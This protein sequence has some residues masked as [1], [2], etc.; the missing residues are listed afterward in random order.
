VA[1]FPTMLHRI[2][3]AALAA[4]LVYTGFRLAHPSEFIH[5]Y[6]IG[7]EQLVIFVATIVGVLAT[8]LLIGIGIGIGM[9][10]LIHVMNGV[11]IRSLFKPYLEVEQQDDNTVRIVARQSA[12]FSNWIP[13]R[14]QLEDVGL[15]QRQNIVL[16]VSDAKLV[17]HSVMEK[18]H[19]MQRDFEQEGLTLDIIGL[20]AHVPLAS[21]EHAARKRGMVQFR[22]VVV[23]ADESLEERLTTEFIERGATGYTSIPCHGAGRRNLTAGSGPNRQ[24]RIEVIVPPKTGDEILTFLRRSVMPDY[25][26][27]AW[28]DRVDV[29]RAEQFL[30]AEGTSSVS[31]SGLRNNGRPTQTPA[32]ARAH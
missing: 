18:L 30:P 10:F 3:L 21:H 7:R 28:F 14:R 22:R 8:D 29:V 1:L 32:P 15:V 31:L 12:V 25:R 27:T 9:K 5:V 11:P 23:V 2:P 16:D 17:D 6:Q 20:D 19:E 13:F 24:V 26:I 4:M